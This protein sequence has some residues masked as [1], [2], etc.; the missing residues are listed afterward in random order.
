MA[1]EYPGDIIDSVV[2][3]ITGGAR[4]LV[5]SAAGGVRGAG[6]SVQQAVDVPFQQLG[7]PSSPLRIVDDPLNGVVGAAENFVN[8]GIIG[9]AEMVGRGITSG[10]DRI[11]KTLENLGSMTPTGGL[12][13][14][15]RR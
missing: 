6:A 11:P 13:R 3:G 10:L 14:R 4:G 12:L 1:G 7:I 8:G 9:S 5:S 15:M 2:G